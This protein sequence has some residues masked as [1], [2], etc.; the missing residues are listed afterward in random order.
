MSVPISRPLWI[1]GRRPR[2]LDGAL[3][4]AIGALFALMLLGP[5]SAKADVVCP[6]PVPVVNE[7]QCHSGTSSWA[8]DEYSQDLGGF[9]TKT[10]VNLGESVTLKIGRDGPVSPT[11]TM[12]ISV[13]RMGYYEGLGAR[14]VSS[15]S[16][17]AINNTFECEAM[18]P[19]TGKVSCNNWKATYTIPGSSFPASG[20]YLAKLTAS[21]GDET[22]VVFT[23]R[24]DSHQPSSELLYVLPINDYQAYN[25]FGGKSLYW[26]YE[27]GNT[28]SG[29]DRAVKVSFDRPFAQAGA[30]LNWFTGPDFD[31][32]AWLEKQGYDVA[33]TDDVQVA[34]HPAELL[35]HE[36]D[37]VSGHS[38]YWTEQQFKAFMAAR[39]AGVNI[40]SFSANTAY[41]KVRYEDGNR[42]LVC[43]KTVQGQ[44]STGS[45]SISDND[46]GPDGIKGTADD[47]LG[48]DG[49]AG[50]ADDNPQNS[51]TTFRDNGAPPGDPAAPPAAASVPTCQRTSSSA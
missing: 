23:V 35:D 15:A 36:A 8:V 39:E 7:N 49:K 12:N 48:L 9:P 14:Q 20:V 37:V 5:A 46:W 16:N 26:G 17:V 30:H 25:T 4:L 27:G 33:Y 1:L 43:Y 21:T 3:A 13:Y 10:S 38:E 11:R 44:G 47:A 31:L 6:N 51:T 45:G 2:S 24:D 32:L 19:Q 28:A 18:D 42:T 34:T 29:T 41:W 50:T 40:A 22:Q